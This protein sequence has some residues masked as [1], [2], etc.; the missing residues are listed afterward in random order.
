[1]VVRIHFLL[2]LLVFKLFFN[3]KMEAIY[4]SEMKGS[5]GTTRRYN[6]EDLAPK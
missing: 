6:P 3:L 1:M 4:P 5:V 2:L